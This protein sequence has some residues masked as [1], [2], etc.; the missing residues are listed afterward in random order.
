MSLGDALAIAVALGSGAALWVAHATSWDLGGRSP[1][2]NYDTAQYAIAARELAQ[3]GQ[4]ATPYALPIE[5]VRTG[6]PPWPLAVLQPGLVLLEALVFR[7][8]RFSGV[9]GSDARAALTLVVPFACYLAL[10]AV[11]VL[12]TFRVFWRWKPDAPGWERRGAALALAL[13]FL[14][15]PEAQHFAI[16]GFT[17]L[18]FTLGLFFCLLGL[19]LGAANRIP[20]VYGLALGATA[21]FRANMLWLAPLFA[22]GAMALAEPR[23]RVRTLLWIALGFVLPLAP[24]W[25]YKWRTFGSP[26]WDL[27]RYVI[28]D[29]IGG[30]SWFSLYHLPE[31]PIVP[32]GLEAV[33]LLAGKAAKNLPSLLLA[34]TVGP[35][36][37]WIGAALLWLLVHAR[38]AGERGVRPLQIAVLIALIAGVL[39]VLS[40]AISIPWLRYLFPT[41]VL[42]EACGLLTLWGLIARMPPSVGPAA[43]RALGVAVA[44]LAL[45]WGAWQTLLG[46]SEAR[47]TSTE[48]GVP[49]WATF[50]TLS[51]RISSEVPPGEIVMSNLGPALAWQTSRPV[52]HLA[53]T[54]DDVEACRRRRDFHHIVL[55]FRDAERA[56]PGWNEIVERPGAA[57]AMAKLGV[58]QE[59]RWRSPD[60][61]TIVWLDLGPLEPRLA[62]LEPRPR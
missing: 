6:G 61:F 50:S 54:P 15:D 13:A 25:Y 1:V 8:M 46:N 32:Q 43:R 38:D 57:Q 51:V 24:W 48:R 40:T 36:A 4:L 39:G 12:A 5:L 45:G 29:G 11:L 34:L 35:R 31:I 59:R 26:S 49:E 19:V 56:W 47:A 44:V 7:V 16:G 17:E 28:W 23:T 2:I 41:R 62:T 53:L 18:P 9:M 14:L 10:A 33:R 55:A 42:L 20:F 58:I 60:G 37:L 52:L 27:T 30:R 21:L 3:H 22:L